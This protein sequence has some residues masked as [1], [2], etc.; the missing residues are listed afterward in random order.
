MN[1][2]LKGQHMLTQMKVRH[3]HGQPRVLTPNAEKKGDEA[4]HIHGGTEY[5]ESTN[6]VVVSENQIKHMPFEMS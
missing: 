1:R 2:D 6:K 3:I 4:E 5:I